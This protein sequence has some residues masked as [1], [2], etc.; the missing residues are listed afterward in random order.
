M[1]DIRS[2]EPGKYNNALAAA[3]KN[4]EEFKKPEWVDFVKSGQ[5]KQKMTSL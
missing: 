3:L 1:A 5:Q 4:V 2:I